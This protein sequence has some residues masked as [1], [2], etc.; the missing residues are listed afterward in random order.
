MNRLRNLSIRWKVIHI[1][2]FTMTVALLIACASF[3]TYDYV[4]FGQQQV[5]DSQALADMLGTA[6]TAALSF[7]DP[8]AV[9]ETL[10]SLA[11]KPEVTQSQVYTV[12]GR[13]FATYGRAGVSVTSMRPPVTGHGVIVGTDRIGVFR[14]IVVEERLGTIYLET[15]RSQQRERV[16]RFSEIVVKV[17]A[18][19]TTIAFLVAWALQRFISG[20]ILHL[21]AAARAVTTEKSYTIRVAQNSTDEVG[22]L[23]EGF[24]EMLGEIQ[25]RDEEL[26][27]HQTHLKDEVAVRTSELMNANT[28]LITARDKAEAASRAKS[29]FLANMSHEIRTPM[30]GIIGMT[31]L[32]LDTEL[33]GEQREYLEI[34][35]RVGRCRCWRSSTTFS[36]SRRSK[37]GKLELETLDFESARHASMTTIEAAGVARARRKG[38]SCCCDVG[39]R[40]SRSRST[41]TRPAASGAAQSRRQRDQ[42]HRARRGRGRA[43]RWSRSAATRPYCIFAVTDT[44]IGIPLDKQ[45]VIFEAIQSRPTDR[46]RGSTAGPDWGSRFRPSLVQ[47]MGGHLW[48]ESTPGTG[49][50]FHFTVQVNLLSEA[51]DGDALPLAD[52]RGL[53]VLVVDDNAT[54]RRIFEKTLEKWLMRTTLVDNGSDALIAVQRCRSSAASRSASCCS[55]PTCPEWTASRWPE[56]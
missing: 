38:S 12:D 23:V 30:N 36:I 1:I 29:E 47:M 42:V 43:R 7:D 6:S 31:D 54:N 19:S 14:P 33:D 50:T 2:M 37:P 49:S 26:R 25:K 27:L 15:D 34:D 39:T 8:S 51:T 44:G 4:T 13:Q 48:V 28:E 53:S 5:K 3:M 16:R 9:R 45:T 11:N 46:L 55:T 35:H 52:L 40:C 18:G 41:A 32:L 10:K 17:L 20:P 21:A 56:N 22:T 24:N